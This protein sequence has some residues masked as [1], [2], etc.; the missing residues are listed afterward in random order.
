MRVIGRA[1]GKT[2][3]VVGVLDGETRGPVVAGAVAPVDDAAGVDDGVARASGAV[4]PVGVDR[5]FGA[6]VGVEDGAVRP[7]DVGVV[8]GVLRASGALPAVGL[9]RTLGAAELGLPAVDVPAFATV[10]LGVTVF[11]A[12]LTDATLFVDATLLGTLAVGAAVFVTLFVD[13]TVFGTLTVGARAFGAVFVDATVFGA[14]ALDATE[15]EATVFGAVALD[16]VVFVD[17]TVFG[18]VAFDAVVD[19]TVFAAVALGAAVVVDATVFDTPDGFR[20]GI[21]M[22][23]AFGVSAGGVVAGFA[24]ALPPLGIEGIENFPGPV[25]GADSEALS[26]EPPTRAL[27]SPRI[28]HWASALAASMRPPG[29]GGVGRGSAG[30][31]AGRGGTL[32]GAGFT[33]RRAFSSS[34]I[35]V[36]LGSSGSTNFSVMPMRPWMPDGRGDEAMTS[37]SPSI[38]T[39]PST[40]ASAMRPRLPVGSG[41]AT[42]TNRPVRSA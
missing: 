9:G 36:L 3:S 37:A 8:D 6:A 24:R 26:S 27:V 20:A 42:G 39:P 7:S 16:A 17:A 23:G 31:T 1:S 2:P 25:D 34:A 19:A 35:T 11:E 32:D 22:S 33:A 4:A 28:T 10:L 30:R 21:L 40:S 14:V 15:F 29:V 12:R 18:A 38:M 13:A 5:M 41:S